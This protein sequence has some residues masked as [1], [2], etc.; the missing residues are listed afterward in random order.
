MSAALTRRQLLQ[1]SFAAGIWTLGPAGA[2]TPAPTEPPPPG[3]SLW[4]RFEGDRLTLLHPLTEMGQGTPSLL[5]T[6]AAE[7]LELPLERIAVEAAPVELRFR[8]PFLEAYATYG[9]AG[10]RTAYAMLAPACAAARDMLLRAAAARWG[11]AVQTCTWVAP[12]C[13]R[14]GERELALADLL[15]DAAALSPPAKPVAKPRAQWTR[16][17]QV[18]TRRDLQAKVTGQERYGIDQPCARVACV[19]HAPGFGGRLLGVDEAPALAKPGVFKV[20][21]LPNAVAVLARGYWAAQQG[22]EALQPRWQA[23]ALVSSPQLAA[24]C[25]AAVKAGKG[26]V[27]SGGRDPRVDAVKSAAAFKRSASRL[28]QEFEFPYLAHAPL[29]PLNATVQLHR[30]RVEFWLSTQNASSVQ[31]EIAKRLG[32]TP[33]QVIVHPMSVG[34]GFGRRI[35][36]DFVVEALRIAQSLGDGEPLKLIWSRDEDLRSGFYRPAGAVRAQ[37]A[38]DADGLPLALRADMAGARLDDHTVVKSGAT[39]QQP[40]M[41]STMGWLD[42]PYAIAQVDLRHSR[43]DP[44][45]PV[46]YWR[47]VGA[48]Q[49]THAYETLVD[50]AARRAR[51]DPV[52]YRRRLLAGGD[53]KRQRALAFV[54]ALA[55]RAGWTRPLAKNHFRGFAFN[56]SNRSIAGHVV[57]IEKLGP[58]RFRIVRIVAGMDAGL[59]LN[60]DAV[61]AQLMGATVWGLTAALYGEISLAKGQVQQSNFHDYRLLTLAELPPLELHLLSDGERAG[62]VG[63]EAVPTVAP[64]LGNA[65]LAG[66]GQVVSKLPITR[67]GWEWVS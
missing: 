22:L 18:Q 60:P 4:L 41:A 29:E 57:E 48:S 49:N 53:A 19:R 2:Q 50:L 45:V 34:G 17:G 35:E 38:L 24:Q 11:V 44:G 16:L 64:A 10:L 59:V 20:I 5:A 42:T 65:L 66:S 63:E 14:Q 25:R 21:A 51:Q 27:F 3:F 40:D 54:D 43:I 9:S 52:T 47:S 62:G 8:N 1:S 46:C 31:D 36:I 56:E 15:Q 67:S 61:R 13:A 6:I 28:A 7:E 23:G 33:E 30:D 39:P 37:F 58:R 26:D 12:G 32:W 55:E